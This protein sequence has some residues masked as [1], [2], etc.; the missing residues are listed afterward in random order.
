MHL[1]PAPVHA[2][3]CPGV[4]FFACSIP[5]RS[6]AE[7]RDRVDDLAPGLSQPGLLAAAV[8]ELIFDVRQADWRFSGA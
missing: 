2:G 3:A 7:S 4:R 5:G 1:C 6:R 8:E